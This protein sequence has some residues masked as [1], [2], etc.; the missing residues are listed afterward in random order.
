[1]RFNL[2]FHDMQ[3]ESHFSKYFKKTHLPVCV[4]ISGEYRPLHFLGPAKFISG[5]SGCAEKG[6][7]KI[8]EVRQTFESSC[9]LS[10]EFS[11]GRCDNIV[12]VVVRIE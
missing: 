9:H 10:M 11:V 2:A 1:M 5:Q 12:G 6:G 8:R 7:K 3:T 4:E